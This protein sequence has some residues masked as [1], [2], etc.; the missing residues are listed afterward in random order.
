MSAR[1]PINGRPPDAAP[2]VPWAETCCSA[3]HFA[4][5]VETWVFHEDGGL[6][7]R[8]IAYGLLGPDLSRLA[9]TNG[10]I[11]TGSPIGMNTAAMM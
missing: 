6:P 5:L 3:A 9:A 4:C 2:I 8:A 1:I 7:P 11:A 10:P